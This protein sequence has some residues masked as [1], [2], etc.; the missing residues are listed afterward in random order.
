[1]FPLFLQTKSAIDSPVRIRQD[2]PMEVRRN[3]AILLKERWELIQ[4]GVDRK[5]IK[6]DKANLLVRG[7]L[8]GS[9]DSTSGLKGQRPV[10]QRRLVQQTMLRGL[11]SLASLAAYRPTQVALVS[12][13][14]S[15]HLLH[16]LHHP[17]QQMGIDYQS[18]WRYAYSIVGV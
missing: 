9:I 4:S 5:D 3:Q 1:M 16:N 7:S 8:Y 15:G 11:L 13:S 17:S 2:L 10:K 12:P 6:I 14:L 18:M